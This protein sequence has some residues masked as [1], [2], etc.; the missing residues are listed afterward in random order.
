MSRAV[1]QVEA[2]LDLER[3]LE[4]AEA[5]ATAAASQ[6]EHPDTLNALYNQ[7]NLLKM[8]GR[9]EGLPLMREVWRAQAAT[10]GAEH[11]DTLFTQ[12]NL[13]LFEAEEGDLEGGIDLG[14]PRIRSRTQG[15]SHPYSL[16]ALFL[17]VQLEAATGDTEE[18]RR[19]GAIL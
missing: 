19:L 13:G 14:D 9:A 8:V 10:V 1:L 11:P 7:S 2:G 17:L 6:H 12:T 18:A 3:A 4:D 16:G 15:K 5:V